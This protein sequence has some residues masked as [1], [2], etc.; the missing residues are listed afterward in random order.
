[1][2]F[3][4]VGTHEQPF[5]R[6]IEEV[7]CLKKKILSQKMFLFKQVSPLMSLSI[8][9]GKILFRMMKWKAT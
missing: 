3:V 4:T 2:I 8:A 6:L 1:M 7:D 9:N 5:N